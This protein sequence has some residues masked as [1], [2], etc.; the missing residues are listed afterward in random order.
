MIKFER[1]PE[2]AINATEWATGRYKAAYRNDYLEGFRRVK[3]G[4]WD[5]RTF[6][7][8]LFAQDL[9]FLV[10]F[11]FAITN[12]DSWNGEK[13][14]HPF[15]VRMCRMV[16]EGPR[17]GTLDIWARAHWKSTVITQ[18]ETF[19][20]QVRNPDS[21]TGIFCYNRP[22]A[23][24][25]LRGLKI[26]MEESDLLKWCFPAVLW[27]KPETEA[28]KW[29]E[30]DGLV[31]K[32]GNKSRR[33]SSVEAHGL[34]EGM[35][36]G[37]HFE[38]LVFDD[39]ETDDIR[40][41]PDQLD[42]VFSKFQMA[43]VNL[44]TMSDSNEKRVIGTYYS[45]FGPNVRIRD[46]KYPDG[47]KVFQLR[48]IPGSVDGTREGKPVLMDKG[49]WEE[50]KMSPHF[51]SQ[52]L[53][54]PTPSS[55]IK[56]DFKMLKPIEPQFVPRDI[57]KFM[58]LD[59]AGGDETDKVSKDLWSF[60]VVGVEPCR[61]DIG[62]SKVFL[63]DC[64]AAQMSHSEGIDG[65]VRMYCRNG[66]IQQMG[67]E[68]VGLS[69]TEMHITTALRAVGRR[70]SLDAGNLVLLKPAGRSKEFRVESAL[71]W[72]LNNGM[73]YYSTAIH[74]RYIGIIQEEMAKFPFFHTDVL[75]MWAYVYDMIKTFRFVDYRDQNEREEPAVEYYGQSSVTGY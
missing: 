23:K 17:T 49:A 63:L 9:W 22:A 29:S 61:N 3:E 2:I 26:L 44:G 67:V 45:H 42:K 30:D 25:P 5:E 64:E 48:L 54:D 46:M 53:C 15:V 27:G 72:P 75:D 59:Q 1:H 52:Q 66:I 19:Q 50:A 14:H 55:E 68:K 10:N 8:T 56:L 12:K 62:Q 47:R 24:K 16:E 33:E 40:D 57:W 11:G 70:L 36:T 34:I 74:S 60:G 38:R 43:S 51:N 7:R 4:I 37:S 39:L 35:P 21:C 69:T 71:Q 31:L 18:A 13:A 41:S 28:P 73:L 65:V 32:R 20:F 58:V 6:L